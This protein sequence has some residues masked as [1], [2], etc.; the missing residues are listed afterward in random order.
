MEA[1]A[2]PITATRQ[3]RRVEPRA[4]SLKRGIIVFHNGS[5]VFDCTIRNVSLRGAMLF[6]AAQMGVPDEF[7]LVYGTSRQRRPCTVRWRSGTALGVLFKTLREATAVAH[8]PARAAR[9]R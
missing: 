5:S 8:V 6:F 1:Q 3:N 4:R 7:D 2:S 9:G